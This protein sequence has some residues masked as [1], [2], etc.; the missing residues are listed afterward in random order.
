[1]RGK[2]S[3]YHKQGGN[4]PIKTI[5]K[6]NTF[7]KGMK[8]LFFLFC[9]LWLGANAQQDAP[10]KQGIS[11]K[12]YLQKGD[13][14]PVPGRKPGKGA[15]V[16]RTVLVYQLTT[17]KQ[18]GGVTNFYNTIQTQLV[19]KTQ[20]NDK[21]EYAIALPEGS[22]SVFVQESGLLYANDFDG[23]GHICPVTVV[24]DKVSKKD[25]VVSHGGVD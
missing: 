22:Y 8:G 18:V 16:S 3:S 15:P 4:I 5:S 9:M 7:K 25:V 12:I 11:G 19:A 13:K 14:M 10:V 21:G 20:S 23:E 2:A 1:M 6:R 24:A 17:L